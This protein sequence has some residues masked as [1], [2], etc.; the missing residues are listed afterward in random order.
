MMITTY[1][2]YVQSLSAINKEIDYTWAIDYTMFICF[3]MFIVY[4]TLGNV[5]L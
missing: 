5:A 1:K 4:N 3:Y 2:V